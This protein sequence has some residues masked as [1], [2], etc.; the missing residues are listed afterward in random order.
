M[1]TAAQDPYHPSRQYRFTVGHD[2]KGRW[3]VCDRLGQVGGLFA[4][5]TS[6]M[7]FAME[8][9]NREPGQIYCIPDEQVLSVNAIFGSRPLNE[10]RKW[11]VRRAA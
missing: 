4:D 10:S 2:Q 6:A 3:L 8:E 9:S 11:S 7:H 1:A 5:R